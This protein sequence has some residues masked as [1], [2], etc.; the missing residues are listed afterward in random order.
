MN[1]EQESTRIALIWFIAQ[2]VIFMV[3]ATVATFLAWQII[4]QLYA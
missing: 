1:Y 4:K 3:G 2:L